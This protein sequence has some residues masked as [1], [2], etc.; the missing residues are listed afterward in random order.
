MQGMHK[1]LQC[2]QLSK[3]FTCKQC[4]Q[5]AIYEKK[6]ICESLNCKWKWKLLNLKIKEL[7]DSDWNV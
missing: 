2:T 5:Y 1:L 7:N 4:L 3:C 6:S